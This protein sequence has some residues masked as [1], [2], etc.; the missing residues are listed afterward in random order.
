MGPQLFLPGL[1]AHMWYITVSWRFIWRNREKSV[2]YSLYIYNIQILYRFFSISPYKT[3]RYCG[4]MCNLCIKKKC[5]FLAHLN[6]KFMWVI[7]ITWHSLLSLSLGNN[8]VAKT[9]THRIDSRWAIQC[10]MNE[11]INYLIAFHLIYK[12]FSI[13]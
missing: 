6:Q 11:K 8:P 13:V 10:L 4:Y 12:Q 2:Y 7:V 3:S 5:Y 9:N 1:D